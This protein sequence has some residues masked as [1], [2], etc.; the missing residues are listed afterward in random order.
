MSPEP[1]INLQRRLTLVGA[2]RAGG[3][4]PER[5]V[6]RK[7]EAWRIT[8]PRRQLVEQAASIFGGAVSKWTSPVGE[9]WQCY[10]ER[11]ELDVLVMPSY[12][13]RQ[14]YELWEGATKRTRLCDGVEDELSGQPCI[15]N[16]EGEDKCDLYTRLVVCLPALDTLLGWRLI[17]RGAIA[18][19]ELPTMMALIQAQAGA[20]TFVPAKLRLDQRR[21]VKDGQ[22]VRYVVPVL[23]LAV[24]YLA[25]AAPT[26]DGSVRE[27]PSGA[28]HAPRREATVE[29]A[30]SAVAVPAS[31]QR[32]PGRSAAAFGPD[33][34]DLDVEP[35]PVPPSEP[36]Q[37]TAAPADEQTKAITDAQK[38]KL[39]VL[40]GT[41][42]PAHLTTEH[43]WA[44]VAQMRRLDVEIMVSVI[45]GAR[46]ESGALHFG[47]LRDSLTRPEA[48]QLIDRLVELEGRA[49]AG[50]AGGEQPESPASTSEGDPGPVPYGEFPPGY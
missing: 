3:E 50:S 40:I 44:A 2:I 47:P 20:Q 19:H 23:D 22:T 43:L 1:L 29:Q 16:A 7:L 32:S 49:S 45:E 48:M 4:K 42:R 30:L 21:G 14:S 25:L 38:R 34:L 5:G 46:D 26:A 15:C 8:S 27:L 39:N 31:P 36:E 9:E 6:G 10:S 18:G 28:T 11:D 41:L 35:A 12:S 33:D 13:V 24:S 17:T 37:A